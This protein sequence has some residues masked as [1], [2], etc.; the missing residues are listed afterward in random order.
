MH[1]ELLK[2]GRRGACID[3]SMVLARILDKFRIW[4]FV[5]K[6]ALTLEFPQKSNI[7]N[8]YYWPLDINE[9]QAGHVWV[10][11]P[12]YTI[13]D[14]TLHEQAYESHV[15]NHIPDKVLI[16]NTN[17]VD[18][19]IKDLCSP[20]FQSAMMMNGLP[21]SLKGV[22]LINPELKSFFIIF[23]TSSIETEK[24]KL[25]YIPCA[26]GG[27]DLPLEQITSLKLSGR[28]GYQIYKDQ[29]EPIFNNQK[30]I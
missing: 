21:L 19:T 5:M 8:L 26:I 14:L 17:H 9:S 24:I 12:P 25:K 28:T 22:Q 7:E 6:G 20:E 13:I 27:S 11:A 2:D 15:L 30:K 18:I 16:K 23:K 1:A 4:N 10:Y 29:I 3:F